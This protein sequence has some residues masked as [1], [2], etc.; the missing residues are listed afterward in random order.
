MPISS[1]ITRWS[2]CPSLSMDRT[3]GPRPCSSARP[4]LDSGRVSRRLKAWK[5]VMTIRARPRSASMSAG[6]SSRAAVVAVRVVRVQHAQPVT[7]GEA[8]GHDEESAAEAPAAG[9]AHRVDRLPGDDH[10]HD[11]GL[12]RPRW[13]ASGPAGPAPGWPR[14][15][16]LRGGRG[17]SSRRRPRRGATSVEPD[18]RLDRLDLAEEGPDAAEAV[19]APVPQQAGGLRRDLPIARLRQRPPPVHVAAQLVDD[20]RRV[21]LLGLRGHPRCGPRTPARPGRRGSSVSSPSGWE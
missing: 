15:W 8:G 17:T 1:G 20:G 13:R 3:S 10:R 21:V 9:T 7:N 2:I 19:V 5:L 14:R 4:P 11:G 12:A 6:T 16:P 18:Q